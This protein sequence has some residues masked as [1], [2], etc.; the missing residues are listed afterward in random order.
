MSGREIVAAS[1]GH[2]QPTGGGQ[3]FKKRRFPAAVLADEKRDTGV[4]REVERADARHGKRVLLEI[5][6]PLGN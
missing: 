1:P 4:E 6:N 5:G 3:S 2:R